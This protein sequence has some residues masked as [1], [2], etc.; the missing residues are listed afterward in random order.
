[1]KIKQS[2]LIQYL[3]DHTLQAKS[4]VLSFNNLPAEQLNHKLNDTEWSILECLEH[5]NR[6]GNFYLPEIEKQC[7]KAQTSNQL[8]FRSS[9]LGDFFVNSI[10]ASNTKKIKATKEMDTTGSTLNLSTIDQL[11]KQLECLDRLLEKS[12]EIDLNKVKTAIS[13]TNLVKLKLGDTFRFLVYHN[14]RHILQAKR[15]FTTL[16]LL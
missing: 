9:W 10:K 15:K 14:E 4:Q 13:L 7:L 6:Y 2:E 16:P 1:M 12:L 3:R 5:L 8:Y 11:V